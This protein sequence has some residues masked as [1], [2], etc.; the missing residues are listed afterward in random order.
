[1]LIPEYFTGW[2][3]VITDGVSWSLYRYDHVGRSLELVKRLQVLSP[4]QIND[5]LRYVHEFVRRTGSSC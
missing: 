2:C 4:R 3:G 5:L 1:M